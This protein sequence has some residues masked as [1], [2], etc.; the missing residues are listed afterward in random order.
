MSTPFRIGVVLSPRGWSSRLHAF[1]A[2]HVPDVELIV[3]RDRRAALDSV[4]H[5][6]V[7]DGTTPWLTQVFLAEAEQI[8][9]RLVGVYDRADG[10]AS[11]DRLATLGLTHLLEE[12]MPPEDIVFL[13]DRLRPTADMA[14]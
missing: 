6:L 14:R 9:L 11:R 13:L 5:V 1:V 7:L 4:A 10:G 2:D 12:A 8:G 3:V